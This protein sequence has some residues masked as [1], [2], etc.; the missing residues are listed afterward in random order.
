MKLNLFLLIVTLAVVAVVTFWWGNFS[1]TK[2]NY[3][4]APDFSYKDIKGV[5]GRLYEHEDKIILIHFWAT[6]C[7]PCLVEFPKIVELAEKFQDRLVVFGVSADQTSTDVDRFF[8]QN[9]IDLPFNFIVIV[10]S[11]RNIMANIYGVNKLPESF[12]LAGDFHIVDHIIGVGD[13]WANK[14]FHNKLKGL[15]TGGNSVHKK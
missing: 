7:A 13:Q 1:V 6:W 15:P 2:G 3:Q 11:D 10:E 9:K 8:S 4:K 5:S 12:L 14:N